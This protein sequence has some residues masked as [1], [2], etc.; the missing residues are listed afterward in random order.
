[1]FLGGIME[2]KLPV[3]NEVF[4]EKRKN[5]GITQ[6]KLASLI[7]KSLGT[8]KRYD[9]GDTIPEGVIIKLCEILNMDFI[10]L[11]VLQETKN[12]LNQENFYENLITKYS[13]EVEK[14]NSEY[15]NFSANL[16]LLAKDILELY[17]NFYDTSLL[18]KNKTKIIKYPSYK[19][20]YEIVENKIIISRSGLNLIGENKEKEV[21]AAF[22]YESGKEFIE[23]IKLFFNF[24]HFKII[25]TK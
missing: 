4:K 22:N 6:E 12:K 19:Y 21:L 11:L 9:T 1:M 16:E 7:F 17:K 24:Q 14:F 5:K 15:Y 10:S 13:K 18:E 3:I 23:D 2:K 25:N 8:V 20:S